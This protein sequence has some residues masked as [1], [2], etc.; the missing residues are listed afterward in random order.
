MRAYAAVAY[1][2]LYAPIALIVLFSFNAGRH[3]ADFQGFS[4]A[5]Y[6]KALTNPFVLDALRTSLVVGFVSALLATLFGTMAALALQRVRGPLRVLYDGL[7]YVAIMVPGIVIGIATLV[8][9][10]TLFDAVNPALAAVWPAVLG[11]A[12]RLQLGLGSLVAAHTLFTMALAVL[13][14]RARLAGM[15]RSLVE[16]SM[17]LY[18]TPL[19]TFRQVTLPQLMPAIV[20]SFLLAFTFSFDDFVIAFFVAG[21]NTTL[22]IYVFASIRRGVTPEINAIGTLVLAVSLALMVTAQLL[23]RGRRD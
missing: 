12:P 17:D 14:V 23:L 21:P 2:F 4:L 15:D 8:A 19:A 6:G 1:L 20:A 16:A 5:W 18:A 3:A 9:L 7:I 13:I 10:V 11:S 22:P